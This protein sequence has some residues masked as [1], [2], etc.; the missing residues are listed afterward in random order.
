[1][2]IEYNLDENDLLNH[3]LFVASK[4]DRIKKKRKRSK[5]ILPILYTV[6]ALIL[7]YDGKH[8]MSILFLIFAI[9]WFS[10]YPIWE[11][12][13]YVKHYQNFIREH[14]KAPQERS[15]TITFG[16][17]FILAIDKENESKISTKEIEEINEIPTTIFVRLKGGKSFILPKE[18]IANLDQLK[19]SLKELADYLKIQYLTDDNWEWK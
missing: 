19:T 18:K 14:N 10:L 2:T 7:L 5:I 11:K 6:F 3:Q 4:S 16:N 8:I 17:D 15:V 12:R 9:L 1:M 13:H